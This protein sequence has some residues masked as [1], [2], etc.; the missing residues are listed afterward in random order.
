MCVVFAVAAQ[1]Q[2]VFKIDNV[3]KEGKDFVVYA[4]DTSL[5]VLADVYKSIKK[6]IESYVMVVYRGQRGSM[7]T[8]AHRA[9][10]SYAVLAVDSIGLDDNDVAEVYLSDRSVYKSHNDEWLKVRKGQHVERWLVN[11]VSKTLQHFRTVP[12]E[13]PL[14]TAIPYTTVPKA[15]SVK[16]T[17]IAQAQ[18][19]TTTTVN[20]RP[21]LVR[22]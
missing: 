16:T 3:V 19:T 9:N 22:K 6:D 10:V 7:A 5:Y 11:G 13:V 1:A 15:G 21:A 4:G 18:A 2:Q 8:L 12:R 20:T 14:T 17:E